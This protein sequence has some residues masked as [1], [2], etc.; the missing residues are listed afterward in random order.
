MYFF[1]DDLNFFFFFPDFVWFSFWIEMLVPK[2]KMFPQK[3]GSQKWRDVQEIIGEISSLIILTGGGR[4]SEYPDRVTN[5]SVW[6][7]MGMRF[8]FVFVFLLFF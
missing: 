5:H 1:G 4:L 7:L 6:N 8:V 3:Y 2:L